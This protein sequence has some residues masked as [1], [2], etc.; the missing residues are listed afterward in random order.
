MYMG[1]EAHDA[2]QDVLSSATSSSSS[3]FS[4]TEPDGVQEAFGLNY[5]FIYLFMVVLWGPRSWTR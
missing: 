3:G 5:Y 1:V 2:T 4:G